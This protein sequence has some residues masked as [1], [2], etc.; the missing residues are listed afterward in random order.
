MLK[1]RGARSFVVL[2]QVFGECVDEEAC[3]CA[4]CLMWRLGM[5]RLRRTSVWRLCLWRISRIPAL[6]AMHIN[7]VLR[8]ILGKAAVFECPAATGAEGRLSLQMVEACDAALAAACRTGLRWEVLASALTLEE[9]DGIPCMQ[10]AP[11]TTLPTR[12]CSCTK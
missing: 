7:Q 1:V 12:S 9:P 5:R 4:V 11:S 10:A 6:G 2:K 8:N 3:H